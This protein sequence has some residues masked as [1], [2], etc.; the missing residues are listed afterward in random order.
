MDKN[1]KWEACLLEMEID[2]NKIAD[3]KL[4][5]S[6]AQ[7]IPWQVGNA[8]PPPVVQRVDPRGNKIPPPKTQP[9]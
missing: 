4:S 5:L 9:K 8:P 3:I 2:S 1:G 6:W 7:P